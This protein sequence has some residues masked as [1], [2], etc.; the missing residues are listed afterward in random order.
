MVFLYRKI[1]NKSVVGSE[2]VY[3]SEGLEMES[4][5]KHDSENILDHPI[6]FNIFTA[7][8]HIFDDITNA[9]TTT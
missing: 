8:L 1:V 9:T 7:S 6:L 2:V 3:F 5:F 4:S